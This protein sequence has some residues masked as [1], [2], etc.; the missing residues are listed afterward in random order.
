[1]LR[2]QAERLRAFATGEVADFADPAGA[3]GDLVDDQ[4]AI[5]AL[6]TRAHETQRDV[7]RRQT[8]ERQAEFDILA[9]QRRTMTRQVELIEEER[10]LREVL[11][12]KGLVSR[13]VYLEIQRELK[14]MRLRMDI[15]EGKKGG[16]PS[17]LSDRLVHDL[18]ENDDG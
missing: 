1:M 16:L 6:Q 2:L 18:R 12:K 8:A 14:G 7:L 11:L 3:H 17:R 10:R 13:I 5:L 9:A 15:Q 4:R